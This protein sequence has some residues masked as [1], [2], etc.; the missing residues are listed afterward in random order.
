MQKNNIERNKWKAS[1]E[2]TKH[3]IQLVL[4]YTKSF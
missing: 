4:Q 2:E 3:Y 1:E